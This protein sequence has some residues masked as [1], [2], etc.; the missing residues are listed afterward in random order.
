[1][2]RRPAC[3][4]V[5]RRNP[6]AR[7]TKESSVLGATTRITGN[8]RGAGGIRIEGSVAGDVTVDGACEVEASGE[9]RGSVTAATLDLGGTLEGDVTAQGP[10][11]VRASA[12]ASGAL[13]GAQVTIEPGARVAVEL[14]CDF[15]L[16]MLP[17]RRR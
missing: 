6:M 8:V 1:M 17:G 15:E 13:R 2:T 4:S 11:V 10:I 12:T 7:L 3:T 9:V 5:G 14:D 16:E